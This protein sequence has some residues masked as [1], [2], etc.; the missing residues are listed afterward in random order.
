MSKKKNIIL[1]I[2]LFTFSVYCAL[3]IGES[4]DQKDNLLRGKITLD[5]LFSLGKIDNDII[6]R[7]YYSTIYWSLLYT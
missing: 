1:L 4:W 5:F 2:I 3:T 7:E 6:Y